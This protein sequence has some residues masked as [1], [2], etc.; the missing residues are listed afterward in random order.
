M[1]AHAA[2]WANAHATHPRIHA[3]TPSQFEPNSGGG[4][5]GGVGGGGHPRNLNQTVRALAQHRNDT[6]FSSH[7]SKRVLRVVSKVPGHRT[8][9]GVAHGEAHDALGGVVHHGAFQLHVEEHLDPGLRQQLLE[10]GL[11]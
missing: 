6:R 7:A 9:D 3:H 11:A 4:G 10:D 1:C 5:G 8:S 2:Q